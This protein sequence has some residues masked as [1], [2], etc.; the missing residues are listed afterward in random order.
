LN[1]EQRDYV[2][3]ITDSADI[4][5]S[6]ISNILDISKIESGKLEL[7]KVPLRLADMVRKCADMMKYRATEKGFTITTDI[8]ND[9]NDSSIWHHGDPT[10][11]NQVL[12]NFMSNAVKFTHSGGV[13][14][15]L[16]KLCSTMRPNR[17]CDNNIDTTSSRSFSSNGSTVSLRETSFTRCPNVP[18]SPVANYD[19]LRLEIIDSGCGIADT[20]M[21]FAPFVQAN[22]SVHGKYGGTG[23]GL[24]ISKMI[25]ELMRGR[26]GITSSEGV[27]TTVWAEIPLRRA[28][29]PRKGPDL[30]KSPVMDNISKL[31]STTGSTGTELSKRVRILIAEDNLVNQKVLKKL[32][33]TL[34]YTDITVT[35]N[36]QEAV[37]AVKESWGKYLIDPSSGRFDIILMDCLMPVMD[38]WEATE[39]IR[40]IEAKYL[41][42]AE[43]KADDFP[44][45]LDARPT[46]ILALT[47][48][49]TSEDKLRCNEC[50]MDDHY[51]KPLPRDGLNAMMLHW[52]AK[53]FA[54]SV[55]GSTNSS[56][57]S[58]RNSEI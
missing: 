13:Q 48:N 11:I 20:S 25:V 2:N 52:V 33:E 14:C 12:L 1:E 45:F 58:P 19:W 8:D 10:R 40:T 5:L 42:E 30:M 41:E 56:C 32:L 28:S 47:A 9:L 16:M 22:K 46:I 55:S 38:G 39:T 4:L 44:L 27:G 57:H 34:G 51:I 35:S 26:V 54:D 31:A 7:E 37:D 29:T 50:G 15:K 3:T 23:L 24:N 43:S 49:A 21:L 6:L 17:Q 53:L 18:L 36:G